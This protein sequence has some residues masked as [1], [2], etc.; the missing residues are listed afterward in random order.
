METTYTY[1]K[2]VAA[3]QRIGWQTDDIVGEDK[4]LDFSRYFLPE[5]LARVESLN[6]LSDDEKRLLNHIRGHGY[7]YTFGLLEEF[8]LPLVL[9]HARSGLDMD[10]HCTRTFL[11][12][13]SEE[14]KPI[15]LFKRFRDEFVKSFGNACGV[16]APPEDVAKHVLP[17]HPLAVA[18]VILHIEWMTQ[19]HYFES[20]IDDQALDPQFKSL[21]RHH[22]MEEAQLDTSMVY[23]LVREMDTDAIAEGI[24]GYLKI[25]GSL[26]DGMRAQAAFDLEAFEQA[27]GRTLDENER[28]RFLEVQHQAL[29]WTFIGTGMTHELF[30]AT[31]DQILPGGKARLMAIA[32]N[33]C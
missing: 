28:E 3:A 4:P 16:I 6:F 32:P 25:S 13:A 7:L 26:D 1:E 27:A 30:L 29:R 12:F 19:R 8:I 21:L 23:E 31:V 11:Q 20:V 15:H 33:F 2:A 24:E 22:W 17:H 9:D 10:D 5:S 18:L 14:A